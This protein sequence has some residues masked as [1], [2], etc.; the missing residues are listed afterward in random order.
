MVP[1]YQSALSVLHAWL[2]MHCESA[3]LGRFLFWYIMVWVPG[4]CRYSVIRRCRDGACITRRSER[5]TCVVV[6]AL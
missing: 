3:L 5:P 2:S 6:N 1:V 4:W